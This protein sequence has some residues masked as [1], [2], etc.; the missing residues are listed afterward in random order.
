[1]PL[2]CD[3][4][5]AVTASGPMSSQGSGVYWLDQPG[6]RETRGAVNLSKGQTVIAAGRIKMADKTW[7]R[8]IF[9]LE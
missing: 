3:Q 1:M 9:E 7:S 2:G 6:E 4:A 8:K 5:I